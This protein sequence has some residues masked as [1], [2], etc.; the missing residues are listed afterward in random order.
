M[1]R[2]I[3]QDLPTGRKISRKELLRIKGGAITQFPTVPYFDSQYTVMFHPEEI[4][5][6]KSFE[7]K[8]QKE[9]FSGK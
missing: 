5:I 7:W 1:A 2:I 6:N 3:I 9:N 4:T 8:D